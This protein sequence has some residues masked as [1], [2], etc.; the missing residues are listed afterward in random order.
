M[1]SSVEMVQ[2]A[3]RR[4]NPCNRNGAGAILPYLIL[5]L[6]RYTGMTAAA[7]K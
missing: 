6:F 1:T 4:A 2:D 5:H 7:S 3:C